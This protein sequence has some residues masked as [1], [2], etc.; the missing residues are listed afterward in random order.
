MKNR[1]KNEM[2][3]RRWDSGKTSVYREPEALRRRSGET[4]EE[5]EEDGLIV[6]VGCQ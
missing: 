2:K 4:E 6:G 3:V 1:E 5:E